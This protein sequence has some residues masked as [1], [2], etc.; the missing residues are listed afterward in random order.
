MQKCAKRCEN[1]QKCVEDVK[2]CKSV[3]QLRWESLLILLT[4]VEG[5]K[6]VL[7]TLRAEHFYKND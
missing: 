4:I 6:S 1:V 5:C 3:L 7:C 2:G